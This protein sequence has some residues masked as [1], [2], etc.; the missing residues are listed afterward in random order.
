MVS[1]SGDAHSVLALEAVGLVHSYASRSDLRAVDDVSLQLRAG[2][3]LGIVGESGSGKSTL[4]RMLTGLIRPTSGDVYVFG[5]PLPRSR[6]AIARLVQLVFQDP[7]GSLNPRRRVGQIIDDQLSGLTGLGRDA[8][9][10]RRD[11]LLMLVELDDSLADRYPH[12]LSGGQCQRVAI[13]RSL[14]ADAPILV[15]DEAVSALDVRIQAQIL[16]LLRRLQNELH[17]SYVFVGHDLAVVEAMADHV[18]VMRQGRLVESNSRA[19]LFA[20]PQH[21]YTRSLLESAKTGLPA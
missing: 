18:V 14:A 3:T 16:R 20:T 4:G 19:Q 11:E 10:K 15:L 13:A 9:S 12:E 8:R 7:L 17:L 1:L 2:T 21:P 5:R 6:R